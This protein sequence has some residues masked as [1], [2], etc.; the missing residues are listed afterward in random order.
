MTCR[1]GLTVRVAGDRVAGFVNRQGS[2]ASFLLGLMQ[3]LGV[4][5]PL[6][7][8]VH[9]DPWRCPL[10]EQLAVLDESDPVLAGSRPAE[11][12][13]KLDQILGCVLGPLGSGG[14]R[15]ETD[16]EPDRRLWQRAF[17]TCVRRLQFT[18]P[19]YES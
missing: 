14:C 2:R 7:R 9:R 8:P 10:S 15:R 5:C 17:Q 4:E 6:H 3:P 18:I 11:R 1:I 13:G 16:H 12:G 19:Y